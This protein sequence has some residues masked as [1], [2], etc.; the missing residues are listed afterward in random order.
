MAVIKLRSNLSGFL[1][2]Y[3]DD[4][5]FWYRNSGSIVYHAATSNWTET[6]ESLCGRDIGNP[7]WVWTARYK[8]MIQQCKQCRKHRTK[9]LMQNGI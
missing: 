9:E 7:G 1:N 3:S 5:Q 4:E 2:T 6:G 8:G